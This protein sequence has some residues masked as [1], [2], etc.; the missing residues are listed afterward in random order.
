MQTI[1]LARISSTDTHITSYSLT[2]YDYILLHI[3]S[4]CSHVFLLGTIL[5][6]ASCPDLVEV[7]VVDTK[8]LYPIPIEEQHAFVQE[9][10]GDTLTRD[11]MNGEAKEGLKEAFLKFIAVRSATSSVVRAARRFISLV[12]STNPSNLI[13]PQS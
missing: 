13:Q 3:L 5:A 11:I 10:A 4:L 1:I 7:N 8:I 12:L 2:S 9:L 6:L